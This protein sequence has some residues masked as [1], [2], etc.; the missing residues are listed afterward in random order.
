MKETLKR[1]SEHSG[2]TVEI[3]TQ[4]THEWDR[5]RAFM[6]KLHHWFFNDVNYFFTILTKLFRLKNT[7]D[8]LSQNKTYFLNEEAS[9]FFELSRPGGCF[10]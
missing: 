8:D 6:Q 2:G 7:Q 3:R 1:S 10:R 4:A 5:Q 9:P